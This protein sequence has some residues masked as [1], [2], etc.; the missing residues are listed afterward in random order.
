MTRFCAVSLLACMLVL[1]RPGSAQVKFEVPQHVVLEAPAD[2]KRY[3]KDII[4]AANWL[5]QT[6]LNKEHTKRKEVNAFV[7]SWLAGSPDVE[8]ILTPE[9]QPVYDKNTELLGIYMAAYGRYCLEHKNAPAFDAT[10]AGLMAIMHVYKKGINIM[11][12]SEMEQMIAEE[13]KHQ[14]DEYIRA[15]FTIP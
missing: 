2:Y 6:D 3:E 10:R 8:L 13:R 5:E 1:P 12:S 7:L 4:N 9:L 11:R 14:L 15:K